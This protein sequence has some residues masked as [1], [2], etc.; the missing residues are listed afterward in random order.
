MNMF[1]EVDDGVYEPCDTEHLY[2]MSL[3][4]EKLGQTGERL[5]RVVL[6][7]DA[8]MGRKDAKWGEGLV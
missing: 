3:Q 5:K 7:F 8:F 2:G 6:D 1:K 4:V